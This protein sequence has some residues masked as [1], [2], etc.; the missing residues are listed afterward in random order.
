MTVSKRAKRA[1]IAEALRA[2]VADETYAPGSK[3]PRQEE[4][5][6]EFA[7]S[8]T[9]VMH[10]FGE[11]EASGLIRRVLDGR[12]N[13]FFVTTAEE[14]KILAENA[15][16][17][18][19]GTAQRTPDAGAEHMSPAEVCAVFGVK[20]VKT[21]TRWES[22]NIL[23]PA[24]RLPGSGTRIYDRSEVMALLEKCRDHAHAENGD[25]A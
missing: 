21:L 17:A 20:S 7:C 8:V 23:V 22:K 25:V 4:F 16:I 13:G 5:A 18:A 1:V 15:G 3:L 10:A 9:P 6:A 11:M 12:G 19:S 14:R 24:T 2:R